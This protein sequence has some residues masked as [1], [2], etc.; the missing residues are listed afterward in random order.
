MNWK[1]H[2]VIFFLFSWEDKHVEIYN[3][4]MNTFDGIFTFSVTLNKKAIGFHFSW[5]WIHYLNFDI[6]SLWC[7][8][9]HF[10]KL[11]LCENYSILRLWLVL[12]FMEVP[13]IFRLKEKQTSHTSAR[14]FIGLLNSYLVQQSILLHWYLVS[15]LCPCWASSW[16]GLWWSRVL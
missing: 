3:H 16:P 1:I 6:A 8:L 14:G 11:P 9:C 15:W 10:K 13:Y 7:R 4:A 5:L 12:I 2:N